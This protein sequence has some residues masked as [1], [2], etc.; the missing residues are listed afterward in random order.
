MYM[1]CLCSNGFGWIYEESLIKQL[2]PFFSRLLQFRTD[3]KYLPF[4]IQEAF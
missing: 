1:P 2:A 3:R 4:F